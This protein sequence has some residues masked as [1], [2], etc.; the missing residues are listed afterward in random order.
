MDVKKYILIMGLI[1][2]GSPF[3]RAEYKIFY[4][5]FDVETFVP[6]DAENIEK[7]AHFVFKYNDT[8]IDQAFER[9]KMSSGEDQSP[10]VNIRAKIV[11]LKDQE[12]IYLNKPIGLLSSNVRSLDGKAVA[13]SLSENIAGKVKE[14]CKNPKA[15]F[16]IKSKNCNILG[17]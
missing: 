7:Q 17:K 16:V 12:V 11:R 15:R 5:P 3:A 14:A 8:I 9:I 1:L 10:L 4:I 6:V 13:Q 2:F